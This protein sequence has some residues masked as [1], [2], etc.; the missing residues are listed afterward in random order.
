MP[1]TPESIF[2]RLLLHLAGLSYQKAFISYCKMSLHDHYGI[3]K[4]IYD[5]VVRIQNDEIPAVS[6][7]GGLD[8]S[9][10]ELLEAWQAC[11]LM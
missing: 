5:A 7:G 3:I 1:P 2:E 4:G 6:R 11:C 8:G 10:P 9:H